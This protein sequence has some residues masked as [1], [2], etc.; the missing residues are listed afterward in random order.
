[1]HHGAT[2]RLKLIHHV[3]FAGRNLGSETQGDIPPLVLGRGEEPSPR[4]DRY[5]TQSSR[6][7]GEAA[8]KGL[9]ST[10][11]LCPAQINDG[12]VQ[13]HA[14]ARSQGA[15]DGKVE[16]V[17]VVDRNVRIGFLVTAPKTTFRMLITVGKRDLPIAR[18]I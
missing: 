16:D 6:L 2:E 13:I 11:R 3:I 9:P 18:R 15:A 14:V 4:N 5:V 7:R 12:H 1:M 8:A 17:Y 10:N